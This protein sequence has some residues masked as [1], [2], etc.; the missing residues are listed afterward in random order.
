MIVSVK[1]LH[2]LR[3]ILFYSHFRISL[4]GDAVSHFGNESLSVCVLSRDP[5]DHQARQEDVHAEI[6]DPPG[7]SKTGKFCYGFPRV[8][9][10][11][12]SLC[13]P[14]FKR[15]LEIMHKF[16][17]Y[18]LCIFTIVFFHFRTIMRRTQKGSETK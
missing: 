14:F 8:N 18:F 17:I 7:E 6:D 16:L 3:S 13:I 1:S 5:R 2:F 15:I 9:A 4:R 10:G 12:P 11:K